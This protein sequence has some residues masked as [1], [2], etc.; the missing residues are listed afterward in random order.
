MYRTSA[1]V[2]APLFLHLPNLLLSSE[3]LTNLAAFTSKILQTEKQSIVFQVTLNFFPSLLHH[4]LISLPH[5]LL[6]FSIFLACF[7]FLATSFFLW[8]LKLCLCFLKQLYAL[9]FSFSFMLSYYLS[10]TILGWALVLSFF[11][12]KLPYLL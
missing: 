5:A 4:F 6:L 1:C 11:F 10:S 3:T 12:F 9:C 2:I 8:F 7:L